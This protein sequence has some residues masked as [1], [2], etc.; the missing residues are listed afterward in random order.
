MVV[1]A[2]ALDNSYKLAATF[3]AEARGRTL[4]ARR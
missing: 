1:C 4:P 2:A 3:R